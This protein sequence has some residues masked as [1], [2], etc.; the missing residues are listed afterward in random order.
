MSE[1]NV[2]V[3]RR[4]FDASAHRDSETVFSLF[5]PE[6]EWDNSHG[7]FK[8]LIG[9][10]VYR[11]HEGLR[12]FWHEYYAEVWERVED[13]LQELIE[14]GDRVVSVVNTRARGRA[15]GV[16]VEWTQNAGVWTIGEGKVIRVA[17]FTT[18]EEALEAAGL[19][20]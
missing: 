14:V 11:G 4:V 16:E 10:G 19:S 1:E 6:A 5:D 20:E 13:D 17:W 8:E 3:V 12:Q 9:G 2:E 7:P 15:S 18:L